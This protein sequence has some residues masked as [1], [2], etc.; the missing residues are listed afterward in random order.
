MNQKHIDSLYMKAFDVIKQ[1]FKTP[2]ALI[3]WASFRLNDAHEFYMSFKFI[4]KD[5]DIDIGIHFELTP[6]LELGTAWFEN[7]PI[8]IKRA[9]KNIHDYAGGSEEYYHLILRALTV[10]SWKETAGGIMDRDGFLNDFKELLKV[11][12]IFEEV[13][14]I[15]EELRKAS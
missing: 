4:G 7:D 10:A 12:F 2:G 13:E 1:T 3:E 14:D 6:F 9:I 8:K 15:R 11:A 5:T